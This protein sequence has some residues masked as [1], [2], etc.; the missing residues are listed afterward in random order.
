[1]DSSVVPENLSPG[2]EDGMVLRA[3][4][5]DS[6]NDTI[7]PTQPCGRDGILTKTTANLMQQ[8]FVIQKAVEADDLA[9]LS[10]LLVDAQQYALQ[11]DRQT[12]ALLQE[13]GNLRERM[14]KCE[15]A[16]LSGSPISKLTT[17]VELAIPRPAK[18]LGRAI[19][20]FM[21]S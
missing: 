21:S 17:R 3:F 16:A 14:E 1:M 7:G 13:N 18:W 9:S 19:R 2:S 15:Q 20:S 11:T 10:T 12:M 8:L 6:D 5:I 4:R